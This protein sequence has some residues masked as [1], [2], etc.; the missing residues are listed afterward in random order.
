MIK[1]LIFVKVGFGVYLN[2]YK[3]FIFASLMLVIGIYILSMPCS[4][5]E[6]LR[7]YLNLGGFVFNKEVTH[8]LKSYD[9]EAVAGKF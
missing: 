1:L 4:L 6:R 8:F 7:L 2:P 5:S 9:M 3:Y